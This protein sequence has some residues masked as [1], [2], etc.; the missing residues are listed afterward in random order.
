M[1]LHSERFARILELTKQLYLA[2]KYNDARGLIFEFEEEELLD[3]GLAQLASLCEFRLGNLAEAERLIR[4]SLNLDENDA[5]AWNILGEVLRRSGEPLDSAEAF[6]RSLACDPKFADA[7]SNL[8]NLYADTGDFTNAADAYRMAISINEQHIDAWFNLGNILVQS[9]AFSG[10]V[11]AYEKVL[12]LSPSHHGGL[13]NY[14]QLLSQLKQYG[15]AEKLLSRLLAQRPDYVEGICALSDTF[16][17]R[18]LHL[19]AIECVNQYTRGIT[20]FGRV[21]LHLC[22]AELY[23]EINEKEKCKVEFSAALDI[24][25]TNLT[26]MVGLTNVNIELGNFRAALQRIKEMY[27]RHPEKLELHLARVVTEL[28]TVYRSEDEIAATRARYEI[29]LADLAQRFHELPPDQLKYVEDIIG[30]Q[31]PFLLAYQ[32]LPTKDLQK[33]YGEMIVDAMHRAVL[34]PPLP[35]RKPIAGRRIRVGIV[36]G[37]FRYHSNYKIPIRGWLKHIDHS[38]FEVFGYHTQSKIDSQTEEARSLCDHFIQGPK[39]FREWIRH[40]LQ[41]EIDVLIYPEIGMDPTT[42]QLAC[43]RL[44]PHQATSWGHPTTSGFPTMDYFLSSALMELPEAEE[45]Y[46]EKLVTLPNLSFAYEPIQREKR[47][48]TRQD[49]GVRDDAFVYWSCQTVPKY[50]PQYDW[51]F[52]EIAAQIPNSQFVFITIQ[53]SSEATAV[54]KERLSTSFLNR[55][56]DPTTRLVFLPGLD[57]ENFASVIPLCDLALDTIGWSGCNSSLETLKEGVPIVTAPQT[58]M[59]SRHTAAILTMMGCDELIVT[60]ANALVTKAVAIAQDPKLLKRLKKVVKNSVTKTFQDV[61]SV[62]GL[63]RVIREWVSQK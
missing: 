4:F 61:T 55:G 8:G 48:I 53:P 30:A 2:G 38:E 17:H 52:A 31:Q 23:K 22:R 45:H 56:L 54:F 49:M 60:D 11:E 47:P 33:T 58:F 42:C 25:P 15:D 46:T 3:A 28:P 10:A 44:A 51:I 5:S 16:K 26:A 20:G 13:Y 34:V 43:L 14:G 6:R 18:G 36:S 35:D 9:R 24:D 19:E 63:E 40:I 62:R 7:Y 57:H 41:D 39:P 29:L 12:S 21:K 1:A 50:L 27:A 37:F 32:G 59:R